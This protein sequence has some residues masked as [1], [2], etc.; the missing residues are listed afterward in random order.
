M[1]ISL[2]I[3]FEPFFNACGLFEHFLNFL[4]SLKGYFLK[5]DF[6]TIDCK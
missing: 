6:K 3:E 2:N 5:Q 4:K 1:S